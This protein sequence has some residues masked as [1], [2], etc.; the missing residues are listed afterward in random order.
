MITPSFT[1]QRD[2]SRPGLHSW[3]TS[4][5]GATCYGLI[6]Y[7]PQTFSWFAGEGFEHL[8]PHPYFTG[9]EAARALV[10]RAV[11]AAATN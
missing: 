5:D 2:T 9:H 11:D 4:P 1:Y 8:G 6:S 10:L 7:D 3:I